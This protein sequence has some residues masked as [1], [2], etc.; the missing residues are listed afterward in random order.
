MTSGVFITGT[1]TGIGKTV[2][3][4]LLVTAWVYGGETV[5]AM[6]P[7]ASGCEYTNGKLRNAD[8]I[9][10]MSASNVEA[11]YD[12]VNPFALE[13]PLSPHLAAADADVRIDLGR[14]KSSFVQLVSRASRVVVEGVGGWYVPLSDRATVADM[15]LAL[16]LPVVMVVGMKLGCLNHALLTEQAIH[17]VGARFIGWVANCMEPDEFDL[18][19][20]VE[21]LE[22]RVEAPLLGVVPNLDGHTGLSGRGTD[23]LNA[24]LALAES[25]Q[26]HME[27][28]ERRDVLHT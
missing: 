25:I 4:Q 12:L 1:D 23:A 6:K 2:V 5:A 20:C 26:A 19:R 3:A 15:A 7:V 27:G 13:P 16:E 14:I 8:A 17:A 21:T 18:Q 28:G 24:G 10:L 22:T 11:D 9:A